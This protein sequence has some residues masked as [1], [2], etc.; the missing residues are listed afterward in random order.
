MHLT[1]SLW[2]INMLINVQ[3]ASKREQMSNNEER[4]T[5]SVEKILAERQIE[6]ERR[7]TLANVRGKY[8][9]YF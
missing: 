5:A 1:L 4:Q 6:E 7:Q 3:F 2:R 9:W 8:P